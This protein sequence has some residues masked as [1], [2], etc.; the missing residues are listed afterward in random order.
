MDTKI[1]MYKISGGKRTYSFELSAMSEEHSHTV[2]RDF[3]ERMGFLG[4]FYYETSNGG[5]YSIN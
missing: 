2:A 3:Y 5:C 1:S 4:R